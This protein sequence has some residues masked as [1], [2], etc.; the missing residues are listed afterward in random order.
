MCVQENKQALHTKK[1]RLLLVLMLMY[2]LWVDECTK[3]V[4]HHLI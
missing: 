1:E 4:L 3:S 2:M